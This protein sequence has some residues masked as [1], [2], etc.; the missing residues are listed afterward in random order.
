MRLL[1]INIPLK[2]RGDMVSIYP[3]GDT[4]IGAFN[5]AESSLKK[6]VRQIQADPLARWFGGGDLI[7]CIKPDDFRHDYKAMPNWIF[8][9]DAE[10][11]KD[12][13]ANIT[14]Q[15]ADRAIEILEPIADKCLG[16]LEGNHEKI[17][18]KR[19]TQD[20]QK[21]LCDGL[22]VPNLGSATWFRLIFKLPTNTTIVLVMGARH[23]Y[24]GGRSP[25][26]EPKKLFDLLNFWNDC[27]IVFSGHTHSVETPAPATDLFLPR[28]GSLPPEL[29]SKY[30][31]GANWGCWLRTHAVGPSTYEEDACYP[32]RPLMTV[33]A[34]IIPF[35]HTAKKGKEITAPRIEIRKITL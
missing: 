15:E 17:L 11:I 10:T 6:V 2:H 1:D 20:I 8:K 31:W 34:E 21:Y 3:I 28:R 9:G 25:G 30:R 13:L 33:K 18:R 16:C 29:M 23:G 24:G 22:D 26:A 27:D 19:Y 14:V 12:R 7:N 35:W 4:H 32:P 5:C